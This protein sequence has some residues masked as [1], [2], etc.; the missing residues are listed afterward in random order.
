MDHSPSNSGRL[1]SSGKRREIPKSVSTT[2]LLGDL[3]QVGASLQ[4]KKERVARAEEEDE[5]DYESSSDTQVV[6]DI[7][8]S[9]LTCI[10]HLRRVICHYTYGPMGR[11]LHQLSLTVAAY[12]RVLFTFIKEE[13]LHGDADFRNKSA[14]KD[15][16]PMIDHAKPHPL[17]KGGLGSLLRHSIGN[18]KE[19][20]HILENLHHS[21]H[22]EAYS[23][24]KKAGSLLSAGI[25]LYLARKYYTAPSKWKFLR[26]S[27]SPASFKKWIMIFMVFHWSQKLSYRYVHLNI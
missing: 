2:Q 9:L 5:T 15:A 6:V 3:Y 1:N 19:T 17:L 24:S 26:Q 10:Q 27:L 11:E 14:L 8:T 4:R 13:L 22:R 23:Y 25:A 21:K 16:V 20:T 12:E 18:F 7:S